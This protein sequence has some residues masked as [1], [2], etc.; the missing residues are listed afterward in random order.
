MAISDETS[1]TLPGSRHVELLGRSDELPGLERAAL[2]RR[3]VAAGLAAGVLMVGGALAGGVTRDYQERYG[4]DNENAIGLVVA[5]TLVFAGAGFGLLAWRDGRKAV[6]ALIA[7][8][9]LA[10][11]DESRRRPPHRV[12]RLALGTCAAVA[13][14]AALVVG[15]VARAREDAY[16]VAGGS[17]GPSVVSL[18]A[19]GAGVVMLAAGGVVHGGQLRVHRNLVR[20]AETRPVALDAP[21]PADPP[22]AAD[23]PTAENHPAEQAMRC[24]TTADAEAFWQQ[25]HSW[26]TADPVQNSVILSSVAGRRTGAVAQEEPAV[27]ATVRDADGDIVGVAMR[28]PP[29]A[30]YVSAMPPGAV[31]VLVDALVEACPDNTGVTGTAEEASAFAEQ[32]S[33][34]TGCVAEVA[35][36]QR[37][38]QL[39]EVTPA[40]AVSGEMR[41]ATDVDRDL[42]IAWQAA[43]DVDVHPPSRRGGD[44]AA[45][46]DLRLAE[47][48]A[49]VWDDDGSVSF[50]GVSPTIAGVVRLGPVYTPPEKRGRGYASALVAAVSQRALDD[51]AS[52]CT[53]YTD[54][55]NPTSNKIYAALGYEPV[56]DVAAYTFRTPGS[57]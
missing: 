5:A 27:Y 46:I 34:R 51:G 17:I 48:R 43:F 15:L 11:P 14:L 23:P 36:E 50:V 1:L 25:T 39:D 54:L 26:L 47:Q 10:G 20:I 40:Q 33:A 24:E 7:W 30:V 41:I 37:I 22:S 56:A 9:K 13:G 16:A 8:H 38:H 32:W 52:R 57:P 35:M 42:L 3:R 12:G 21:L 49:Y 53:L 45:Q 31:E 19:M 28:T 2:S 6:N 4:A 55:A 44:F 29:H 18:T